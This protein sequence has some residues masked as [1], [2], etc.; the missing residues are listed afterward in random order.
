MGRPRGDTIH[1]AADRVTG[2]EFQDGIEVKQGLGG[3]E[4]V[5]VVPAPTLKEEQKIHARRVLGYN[6]FSREEKLIQTR[7]V[8]TVVVP[9]FRRF[10]G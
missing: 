4:M 10:T 1:P 6:S 9:V 8:S 2:R 5:V 7:L 3:G